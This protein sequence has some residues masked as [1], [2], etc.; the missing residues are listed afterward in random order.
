MGILTTVTGRVFLLLAITFLGGGIA[1][2]YDLPGI[3]A[4]GSPFFGNDVKVDFNSHSGKLK[5]TGKK[6]FLFD[7]SQHVFLGSSSK[8]TLRVNFD[9]QTGAFEDGSLTF[10]GAIAALGI[11][12]QETLVTADIFG[13]YLEGNT[14]TGGPGPLPGGGFDLWGFATNNIVCS[15][16]LL[17]SCTQSESIYIAL[18]E[19]F[20][21][22]LGSKFRA[23]GFAHTTVPIPAAAWLFGSALGFLAWLRRRNGAPKIGANIVS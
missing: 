12:K 9:K 1:L 17:I 5:I 21:G 20:S 2:A 23:T 6:G 10:S 3:P 13:W 11:P 7:N 16:L 22:D 8:Y 15:P 19:P 18:D 4:S 14:V